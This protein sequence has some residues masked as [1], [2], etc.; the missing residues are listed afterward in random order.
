MCSDFPRHNKA[1]L[2]FFELE[3]LGKHRREVSSHGTKDGENEKKNF[4]IHHKVGRMNTIYPFASPEQLAAPSYPAL[5][6]ELCI[7]ALVPFKP[8]H[9][10]G[11]TLF[12]LNLFSN[13]KGFLCISLC[14]HVCVRCAPC[15]KKSVFLSS[16][17][18]V[19]LYK[20]NYHN[21]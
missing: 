21:L 20:I 17:F 10:Q 4:I 12:D 11:S 15:A 19:Q 18:C 13:W 2:S 3:Q 14:V 8:L 5:T 9:P 1:V 7:S 6:I 16:L